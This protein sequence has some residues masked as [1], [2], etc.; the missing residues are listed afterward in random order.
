MDIGVT[1][2][3]VMRL[4]RRE[5]AVGTAWKAA[6]YLLRRE[7]PP[8]PFDVVHGTNTGGIVPPWN[9]GALGI[10]A[11]FAVEYAA[12]PPDEL[13]EAVAFT[14]VLP[15]HTTFVDLGCGKGRALIVA[16]RLGFDRVIGVDFSPELAAI[17]RANLDRL[18]ITNASVFLSDAFHYS[19]PEDDFVLY[20]FN[21]FSA[22]VMQAVLANLRM[23][24]ASAIYLIYKGPKCAGLLDRAEFLKPLGSPPGRSDV[25]VWTARRAEL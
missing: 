1:F 25:M 15:E 23:S 13:M 11:R 7:F 20:M 6:R 17:A 12:S 21:P 2:G 14:G 22:E 16:A 9:L 4:L 24:S 18:G 19:F 5:G 8:D 3:I 10:N